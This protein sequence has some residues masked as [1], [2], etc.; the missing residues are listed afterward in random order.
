[1]NR[2]TTLDI[3]KLTPYAVGFDR[4]FDN[5]MNYVEHQTSSTGYPPYNI[6]RDGEKF[7]IE[8]ALAGV[9]KEDVTITVAEGVLTIEHKPAGEEDLGNSWDWI[10]K[11][12]AQR[13]FKRNF[14]L[15]DDIVVQGSRME[16]G[17]LYIE[18]ERIIPEEKKPKTIA[19]K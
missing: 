8:I 19:I 17:M 1:M 2:L 9:K 11:G 13:S 16:N 10:H 18:L 7:Q 3:N 15:S 6:I 14:T 4:V 12:I 5:M